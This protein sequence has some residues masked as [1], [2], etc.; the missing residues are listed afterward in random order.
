[1]RPFA[2]GGQHHVFVRIQFRG[3]HIGRLM[4]EL[5]IRKARE[6]GYQIMRLETMN[7]MTEARAL[8]TSV[9]FGLS[10]P[11]YEVPTAFETLTVFIELSPKQSR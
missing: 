9:S 5:L 3:K 10:D 6:V 4:V 8:Y 2:D 1:V 11:Y 7:F